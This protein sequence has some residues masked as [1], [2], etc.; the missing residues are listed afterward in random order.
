MSARTQRRRRPWRM[1]FQARTVEY[2]WYESRYSPTAQKMNATL[3]FWKD[4][5]RMPALRGLWNGSIGA[6]NQVPK[7]RI[8]TQVFKMRIDADEG[9]ADGVFLLRL[10]Q[11]LKSFVAVS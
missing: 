8:G 3:N 5:G 7:A 6:A 11:P 10:R 2:L 1:T 4:A 9:E